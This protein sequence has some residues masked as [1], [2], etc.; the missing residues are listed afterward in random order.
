MKAKIAKKDKERVATGIVALDKVIGGFKEGSINLVAGNAGSGKTIMAVQFLVEGLKKGENGIYITFEE[1]KEKTFADMLRFGWDLAQYEK[2]NRF[3]FIEYTPEQ[4]KKLIT[5]GGGEIENLVDKTKAKRLVIDSITSFSLL[6]QDELT[7]KEAALSF[8]ELIDKWNCT[9]LLTSQMINDECTS[10]GLE[11]EVDSII[12]LYHVRSKG[13]RKRG[14]EILK[15]RGTE[16][17]EKVFPFKITTQG[18]EVDS[19]STLVC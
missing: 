15:M 7:K 12:L 9:A 8:F 5:E 1:K 4:I 13:T 10:I 11:F 17:P 6:Y 3:V 18:V 14:I 19:R 2:Q 16:T